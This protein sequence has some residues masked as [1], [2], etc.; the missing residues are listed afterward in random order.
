M[1]EGRLDEGR[2]GDEPEH[3]VPT[4]IRYLRA[5]Y[6]GDRW[7]LIVL[8]VVYGAL[9]VSI[10]G[11]SSAPSSERSAASPTGTAKAATPCRRG[12]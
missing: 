12:A 1:D 11:T 10:S 6:P 2:L 3:G 9:A 5:L 4:M 7:S 8:I